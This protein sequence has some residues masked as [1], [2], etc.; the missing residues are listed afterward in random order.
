MKNKQLKPE[1]I[2]PDY[3]TSESIPLG[4]KI[5]DQY[6][7]SVYYHIHEYFEFFYVLE[8]KI[9]HLVNGY[10]EIL[11]TGDIVYL[12]P[13]DIHT[14]KKIDNTYCS[15]RDIIVSQKLLEKCAKTIDF[16]LYNT[17]TNSLTVPKAKLS[18][19]ELNVLE[20]KFTYF[21]GMSM[22]NPTAKSAIATVILIDLLSCLLFSKDL[23]QVKNYPAWFEELLSRFNMLSYAKGGLEEIIK[24]FHYNLSYICRVFK[25]YMGI[26]MS[27]HL[28]AIRLQHATILLKT[29]N[30][31]IAE[32]SNDLGFSSISHFNKHFKNRFRITPKEYRK[33]T[34]R[35]N[36]LL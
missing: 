27:Q 28:C 32:I 16:N 29:T 8:G 18:L 30:K 10:S 12:R 2:I 36:A 26:T 25:K 7:T 34:T 24:P 13:Q 19:D 21:T 22:D 15:H 1:W 3:M 35:D 14:F 9:E 20:H 5:T 23:N 17:I 33:L 4:T 11:H 6:D 31:T